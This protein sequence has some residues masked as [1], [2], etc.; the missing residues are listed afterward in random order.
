MS[1]NYWTEK[2]NPVVKNG[3]ET[4]FAIFYYRV[5]PYSKIIFV[6]LLALLFLGLWQLKAQAS[7]KTPLKIVNMGQNGALG[8]PGTGESQTVVA[9]KTGAKYYFPW[10]GALSRIKPE[11]RVSFTSPTLARNAGYLPAANCKGVK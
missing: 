9:S 3:T 8:L 2:I 4:K 6:V 7:A 11:N 10:C 1:I 5:K